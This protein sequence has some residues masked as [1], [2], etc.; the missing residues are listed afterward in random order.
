MVAGLLSVALVA[1]VAVSVALVLGGPGPSQEAGPQELAPR[2][3]SE[4]SWDELS[5]VSAMVSAAASDVARSYNVSVGSTRR[6][7]LADG[8]VVDLTVVGLRADERSDGAGKAGITLMLSP[9]ATRPMNEAAANA[10][11]WE[12]SALR[13][14]LATDGLALLPSD[15]SSRLVSVRKTTNNVG[16][17]SDASALTQTDDLLWLFSASEV[18]GDVTW[19]SDEYGAT[20]SVWTGYVDYT[21]YDRLVSGEGA[22][23]SYFAQAGV[24][25]SSG[26]TGALALSLRGQ[27][28]SWWYRTAYPYTYAGGDESYFYQVNAKGFPSSVG[29]ADQASGI[30][31]GLCL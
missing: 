11:G 14:W 22:Q 18:C 3:F 27:A 29:E 16:A 2:Q 23:Y 26:G 25:G 5:Q 13:S 19:F 28:V 21:A 1:A 6:V 24:S 12:G 17:A 10:G 15:L 9:I 31:V 4:Y 20:P 30:V 8:T 7:R